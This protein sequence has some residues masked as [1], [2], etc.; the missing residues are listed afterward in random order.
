MTSPGVIAVDAGGTSTRALALDLTGTCLAEVRGGPGNPRSAT[1]AAQTI[2]EVSA[3]A[4]NQAGIETRAIAVTMAGLVSYGGH[5]PQAEAALHE[6]GFSCPVELLTDLHGM[7][8][9]AT[10]APQ[11]S[12]LIAGTG[13]TAAAFDGGELVAMSDGLGWL[14]GDCGAGFW[15]GREVARVVAAALD[16]RGQPTSL[17]DAVIGHIPSAPPAPPHRDELA[18]LLAWTYDQRPVD[19]AQLAVFASE[20]ATTDDVA[21]RICREAA[22]LLRHTLTTLPGSEAG[23]IVL[24]GSVLGPHSPIGIEIFDAFSPRT[25]RTGDGIVGAAILALRAAG[26]EQDLRAQIERTR[27]RI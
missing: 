21:A 2:A 27:A 12:V 1:D 15:I 9:S 19:L 16:G 24:G 11:G 7:Y 8:F 26:I 10:D 25:L 17:T 6:V 22:A 20:H 5:Y 3:Q 18:A 14:L 4:A 13:A 23:P